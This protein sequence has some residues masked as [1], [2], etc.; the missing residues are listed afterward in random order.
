MISN[1]GLFPGL[2]LLCTSLATIFID[3]RETSC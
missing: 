2:G 3:T 1:N